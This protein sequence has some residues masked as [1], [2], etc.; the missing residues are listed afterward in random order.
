MT[1]SLRWTFRKDSERCWIV[2]SKAFISYWQEQKTLKQPCTELSPHGEL[3]QI[4]LPNFNDKLRP[5]QR[6]QLLPPTSEISNICSLLDDSV[7]SWW[8]DHQWNG[9]KFE[10][11]L[12]YIT[13]C[14]L[15]LREQFTMNDFPMWNNLHSIG[16]RQLFVSNIQSV[17]GGMCHT[18]EGCS[19]C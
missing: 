18:S 2:S 3:Y 13:L 11:I 15:L 19:L 5:Q 7:H 16:G 8:W 12:I 4:S 1:H 10:E 17:P 6:F 14:I 9:N